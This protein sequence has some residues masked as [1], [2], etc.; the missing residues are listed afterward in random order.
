MTKFIMRFLKDRGEPIPPEDMIRV[1][2]EIK[3]KHAYCAKNLIKELAK[4]DTKYEE[5]GR[6][7]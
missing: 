3:E 2:R 5:D 1:S 7:K 4:Y 6:M